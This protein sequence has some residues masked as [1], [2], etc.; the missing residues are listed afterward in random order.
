MV[1]PFQSHNQTTDLDCFMQY[2]C[3][4][5]AFTDITLYCLIQEQIWGAVRKICLKFICSGL[6]TAK[7]CNEVC[8]QRRDMPLSTIQ[9]L[10]QVWCKTDE[11]IK[12]ETLMTVQFRCSFSVLCYICL[13]SVAR[14]LYKLIVGVTRPSHFCLSILGFCPYPVFLFIWAML[15][16]LKRSFVR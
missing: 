3:R 13:D 7:S 9:C 8:N 11:I 16:A 1:K 6:L 4:L 10:S 5:R 15:T 2:S 14:A 12:T